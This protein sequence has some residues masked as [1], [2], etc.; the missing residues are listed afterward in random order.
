L[1]SEASAQGGRSSTPI[2]LEA[3]RF[4]L[5]AEKNLQL[6]AHYNL[7]L[8]VDRS[9]SMREPDCPGGLSRWEWCGTQAADLA[10]ALD[11]YV[12]NGLTL[13][14]FATEYDVFEHASD[15][16]IDY[17]FHNIGLQLGTRLFEP[18]A[19]R[20]DNHFAHH[21]AN[22]KPLLIVVITDGVPFP[23]FE[24]GLVKNELIEASEKMNK[25][26]EV[27]VIFCQIGERDR[28]GRQYLQDLDKNLVSYG[29]RYHFVHTIAFDE[30][31]EMGLGQTLVACIKECTPP[32]LSSRLR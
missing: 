17:V 2:D 1:M 5:E 13:I 27:T 6:L 28:F 11:P 29:A 30:L 26:D 12:P 32:K 14:P 19:E 24:P 16:H 4:S 3:S 25:A 20:L 10:R 18:L 15:K 9:M 23:R 31:Q 7:E 21:T 22:T 8:L